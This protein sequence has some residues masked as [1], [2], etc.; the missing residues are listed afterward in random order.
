M[1]RGSTGILVL[2]L[3]CLLMISGC[4]VQWTKAI[5]Y[6]SIEKEHFSETVQS[7]LRNGLHI[8]P[9]VIRGKS[10]RF[11]FDTGA[12]LSISKALQDECEFKVVSRGHIIDSDQNRKKVDYV[13]VDSLL[14][15]AV[16]F[17]GQTAFVGDFE[18]N[19]LIKCL[20][21]DGIIGSNLMRHCNWTI[22][23]LHE[24]ISLT[25]QVDMESLGD[26]SSVPFTSDQQYNMLLDVSFGESKI[27]NLTVDY[28]YNGSVSLPANV[29]EVLKEKEMLGEIFLEEGISQSGIIGVP[30][31]LKKKISNVD[32]VWIGD[33]ILE[34]VELNSGGSG[35]IGGHVLSRFIVTIDWNTSNLY[36]QQS[37]TLLDKEQFGFKAGYDKSRG[38]YIQSITEGSSAFERGILTEMEVMK[39]DSLD[40]ESG[41]VFCDYVAFMENAPEE[42]QLELLDKNGL[43]KKVRIKR[44]ALNKLE[45]Q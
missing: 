39:V 27:Q 34:H 23:Y 36:L 33:S 44:A 5:K 38:I 35:L 10:Y 25:D 19:P 16:A 4:A 28:G 11:L 18:S 22:D 12:P 37:A 43:R 32:S 30:V 2:A 8:L 7:E 15:G 41:S 20:E 17:T 1:K 13:A 3:M 42:I 14:I 26:Y 31:S 45:D 6:G 24:S 40:F 21:I 9:V 29:F